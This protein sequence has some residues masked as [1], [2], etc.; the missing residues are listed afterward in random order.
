M[1]K[2]IDKSPSKILLAGCLAALAGIALH[3]IM[4]WEWPGWLWVG[5]G[6]PALVGL[7]AARRL[8]WARLLSAVALIGLAAAGRYELALRAAPDYRAPP[9]KSAQ[10]TG[11]V[12]SV[13][14]EALRIVVRGVA[15]DGQPPPLPF[16]ILVTGPQPTTLLPGDAV[17]WRCKPREA[18]YRPGSRTYLWLRRIGWRCDAREVELVKEGGPSMAR[19]L[20]VGRRMLRGQIAAMMPATEASLLMGLFAGERTGLPPKLAEA[21][22]LTGTAHVLAVSGYNVT[23]VIAVIMAALAYAA[24]GQRR[25]IIGSALGVALFALFVGAG[26]PVLRAALMGGLMLLAR[27]IGRKNSPGP[28]IVLVATG[29][30]LVQPF[31]LRH[32]LGFALSFTAVLGMQ[33]LAPLFFGGLQRR[34]PSLIAGPLA[35][36]LA[37]TVATMPISLSAFGILPWG[38]PLANVIIA[39]LVTYAMITGAGATVLAFFVPLAAPAIGL[40]PWLVLKALVTVVS[41]CAL[42]P[43]Q[44]VRL[45]S[46]Q[47]AVIYLFMG[48]VVWRLRQPGFKVKSWGK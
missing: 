28:G 41:V 7:L 33:Y 23:K 48:L 30:V 9:S 35:E 2:G 38:S 4:E 15:I 36:S 17:T 44:A 3:A 5:F 22:R 12:S 1:V 31:A 19:W 42:I 26:P 45:T 10:L 27:F 37:A 34:L 40:A 18:D 46:L 20:A 24:L 25:L 8:P 43:A 16:G 39:P 47:A 29:M 21:F 14:G 13:D 6:L 11:R 32:D